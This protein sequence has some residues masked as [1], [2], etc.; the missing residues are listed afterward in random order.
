MNE[1]HL[2]GEASGESSQNITTVPGTPPLLSV[3]HLRHSLA[4]RNHVLITDSFRLF[5]PRPLHRGLLC[6]SVL[7]ASA[8]QPSK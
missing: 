6:Q 7:A 2:H 3:C 4:H 1:S 5:V 8:L